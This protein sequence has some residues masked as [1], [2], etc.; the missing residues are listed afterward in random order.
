MRRLSVESFHRVPFT[1]R[2]RIRSLL[3]LFRFRRKRGRRG[4]ARIRTARFT[5][6][7]KRAVGWRR[8]EKRQAEKSK[9]RNGSL[10][11]RI[12]RASC[13]IFHGSRACLLYAIEGSFLPLSLSLSSLFFRRGGLGEKAGCAATKPSND[14]FIAGQNETERG[15]EIGRARDEARRGE[16]SGSKGGGGM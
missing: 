9:N 4:R 2:I 12:K 11:F 5:T 3:P 10:P 6:A 7:L 8:G 1:R 15:E 13:L 16:A 14:R